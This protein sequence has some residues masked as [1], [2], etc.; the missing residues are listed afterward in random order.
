MLR[1]LIDEVKDYDYY[2]IDDGS[3]YNINFV[4]PERLSALPHL[5]KNFFYL[6]YNL[7]IKIA[8]KSKHDDFLFL[9]DDV[10]NLDFERIKDLHQRFK[11]DKYLINSINDGRDSCWVYCNY[12]AP[13][14]KD[15][16]HVGF[17]DCGGLMNRKTLEGFTLN[18][19][20]KLFL[21][22]SSS[23]SVGYQFTTY[24]NKL[25]T[26]MYTVKK[27]LCFHGD[28]ESKMHPIERKK[29]PLISI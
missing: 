12:S 22:P 24:F 11:N 15:L 1:R 27:S 21:Q 2:V 16:K 20:N 9:P 7:G 6:L 14:H 3:D 8:L 29:N 23:S 17:Y 26:P 19:P 10:C 13:N 4:P 5:G 25:K 28:H 18:P